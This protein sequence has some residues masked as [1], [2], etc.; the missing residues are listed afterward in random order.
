MS[1]NKIRTVPFIGV[2]CT[3]FVIV[4]LLI[5]A[6]N[7][8]VIA[9]S[10]KKVNLK[11]SL[12]ELQKAVKELTDKTRKLESLSTK[13]KKKLDNLIDS[14]PRCFFGEKN[15]H[16]EQAGVNG[17]EIDSLSIKSSNRPIAFFLM[18]SNDL[19]ITDT[20]WTHMAH[21]DNS[22][23][24]GSGT[25]FRVIR[26]HDNTKRVVATVSMQD[27]YHAPK[28]WAGARFL[29]IDQSP[30]KEN[31]TYSLEIQAVNGG[32]AKLTNLKFA[33]FE[34]PMLEAH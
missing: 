6:N 25:A 23:L 32:F 1:R 26:T 22:H 5:S 9:N 14:Q 27:E 15:L 24:K 28:N 10:E 19:K 12:I 13:Q 4:F 2:I 34:L 11:D 20:D 3:L 31:V 30:L 18:P 16:G 7:H 29:G 21:I 33:A 8:S 17:K